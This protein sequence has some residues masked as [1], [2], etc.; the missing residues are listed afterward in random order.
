MIRTCST[1]AARAALRPHGV[2]A[3]SGV[4]LDVFTQALKEFRTTAARPTCVQW[5]QI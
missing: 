1:S 5:R 2:R 3:A 4:G